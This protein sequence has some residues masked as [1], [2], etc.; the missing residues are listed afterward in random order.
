M[1]PFNLLLFLLFF[2]FIAAVDNVSATEQ[3]ELIPDETKI[4]EHLDTTVDLS[5]EFTDKNGSSVTL[6]DLMIPGRPLII[7]PVYFLC[8]HL[9][10]FTLNGLVDALNNLDLELG[11][12]F[13]IASFSIN[14]KEDS[15][16]AQQKAKTY[17]EALNNPENAPQAWHFITT[18]NQ[19][20]ITKLTQ[21]LGFSYRSDGK[22][23]AHS[24]VMMVLSPQG[25]ISRYIYGV[26]HKPKNFR[27]ALVEAS[28]GKIGTTLDK[29]FLYCFRFDP[30]KGKY[31]LA[32][33]N[34]A[35]VV[36]VLG[37]I[38]LGGFMFRMFR[39]HG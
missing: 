34:V 23:F 19:E 1:K 13:A 30:T 33:F 5:L 25:K 20:T 10:T 31:S 6:K 7:T 22:E 28:E 3:P 18:Q 11:K 17:Y 15:K 37:L 21:Q 8:P 9:C 12:D 26:K 24:S 36:A 16:L 38:L 4:I 27:L 2:A 35:R 32:V 14:P 29:V 39:M